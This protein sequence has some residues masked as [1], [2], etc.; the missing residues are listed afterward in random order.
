VSG[1]N[2]QLQ[3][4][5]AILDAI[6]ETTDGLTRTQISNHLELTRATTH[7]LVAALEMLR[8]ARVDERGV[9]RLGVRAVRWGLASLEQSDLSAAVRPVLER[10]TAAVGET[11]WFGV[12][13]G[14]SVALLDKVDTHQALRATGRVGITVPLYTSGIGLCLLAGLASDEEI[15]AHID[16]KLTQPAVGKAKDRREVL[17]AVHEVQRNGF[18]LDLG[19]NDAGVYVVAAPVKDHWGSTVAGI[20]VTGPEMRMR[21]TLDEVI[22]A[23]VSAASEVS[24]ALGH[25]EPAATLAP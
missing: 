7:R 11:S 23:V 20:S 6:A 13:S 16:R 10:L 14:N 1:Q 22:E 3:R 15:L 8:L 12:L 9:V 19:G 2:T 24:R 4:V 21:D 18:A 25:R 17:S 5:V